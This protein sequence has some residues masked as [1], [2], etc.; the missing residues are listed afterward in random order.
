MYLQQH[1]TK[2]RLLQQLEHVCDAKVPILFRRVLEQ[3]HPDLVDD[4]GG[5]RLRNPSNRFWDDRLQTVEYIPAIAK[6]ILYVAALQHLIANVYMPLL[7]SRMRAEPDCLGTFDFVLE[8]ADVGGHSTRA[9]A[10]VS[11]VA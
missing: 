5:S 6:L 2:R 10:E 8:L 11:T 1:F 4:D 7:D 3:V 9:A